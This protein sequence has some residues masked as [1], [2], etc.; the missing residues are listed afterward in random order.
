[1]SNTENFKCEYCNC[2]LSSTSSL[3]THKRTN[4]KCLLLRDVEI[5]NTKEF[6]CNECGFKSNL[7][8]HISRHK[9]R[10]EYIEIYKKYLDTEKENKLNIEKLNII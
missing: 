8:H 7:K 10:S 1:M 2:I 4:K 6:T 5:V 3:N 9:C